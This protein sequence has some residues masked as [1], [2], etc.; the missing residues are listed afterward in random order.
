[1][2]SVLIIFFTKLDDAY[3]IFYKIKQINTSVKDPVLKMYSSCIIVFRY[4]E[5]YLLRA[6]AKARLGMTAD[7]QKDLNQIR[8]NRSLKA[9][10]AGL[11]GEDLLDAILLERRREL[12]GE[13]WY[14]YDLMHFK[15]IPRFTKLTQADVDRGVAFWPLSQEALSNNKSLTQN[16]FWK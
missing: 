11:S 6:E 13:G 5:L 1:M 12:M 16:S 4:E 7:A 2:S 9:V 3:P 14:W 8:G 10:N 15:R